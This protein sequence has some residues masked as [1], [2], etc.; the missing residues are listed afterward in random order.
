MTA[1]TLARQLPLGD[2]KG[3]QEAATTKPDE[4]GLSVVRSFRLSEATS[5]RLNAVA[6]ARRMPAS[7][8]IREGVQVIIDPIFGDVDE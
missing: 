6:E 5:A 4:E 1:V 3:T 8:L 7:D 2:T